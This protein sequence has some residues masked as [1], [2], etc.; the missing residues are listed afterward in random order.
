MIPGEM[1]EEG[2]NSL[3]ASCVALGVIGRC[4]GSGLFLALALVTT[5]SAL[6]YDPLAVN[7]KA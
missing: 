7:Q 5:W 3:S 1:T 6:T 2:S 4:L